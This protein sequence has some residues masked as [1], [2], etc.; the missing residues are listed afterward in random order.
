VWLHK[1]PSTGVWAGLYCLPA[2][3]SRAALEEAI[4]PRA[5][6]RDEAVFTHVLTHKD[7]HL[8]PIEAI[9][10]GRR[11]MPVDGAWFDSS[12]WPKLGLPSPIRK[13]LERA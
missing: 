10:S 4:P 8:H 7:L 3:E 11:K 1:R 2:F 12:Q 6:L 13:L 5:Q 9:V